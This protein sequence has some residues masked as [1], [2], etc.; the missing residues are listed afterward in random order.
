MAQSHPVRDSGG[1]ALF[2]HHGK[3]TGGPSICLAMIKM[4]F[5]KIFS[6][7]RRSIRGKP[8]VSSFVQ[9]AESFVI[10]LPGYKASDVS[11]LHIRLS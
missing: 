1:E 2:S 3:G 5:M 10:S 9:T 7:D 11:D 6:G 4:I 8:E